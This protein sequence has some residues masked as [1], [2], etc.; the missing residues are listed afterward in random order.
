MVAVFTK[1]VIVIVDPSSGMEQAPS[2]AAPLK[3]DVLA[4]L[5]EEVKTIFA[6]GSGVY[7]VEVAVDVK[8]AK[9]GK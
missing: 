2:L 7:V 1:V 3:T 4:F 6:R 5:Y 9:A 8:L